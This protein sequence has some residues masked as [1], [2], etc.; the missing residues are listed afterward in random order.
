LLGDRYITALQKMSASENS[1]V[2][3]MPGDLVSA[4]KSLVGGGK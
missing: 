3:V 2:V 4:V 1:K